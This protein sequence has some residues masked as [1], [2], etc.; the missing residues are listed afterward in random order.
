LAQKHT[1]LVCGLNQAFV[2]GVADSLDSDITA[3][4][5]PEPGR[6]CVKARPAS[7]SVCRGVEDPDPPS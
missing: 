7:A 3:C 2:Q 6:C 4:L 5:E 1:A